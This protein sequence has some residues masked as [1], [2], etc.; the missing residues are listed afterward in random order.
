M[1]VLFL[2]TPPT[3]ES[4][5]LISGRPSAADLACRGIAE[6]LYRRIKKD[7]T[8]IG[9]QITKVFPKIPKLMIWPHRLVYCS[10][11]VVWMMP[12]LNISFVREICQ[13]L[14]AFFAIILWAIKNIGRKRIVCCYNLE[15]PPF[16]FS[17][18]ACK[19][20]HT[21]YVPVLHDMGLVLFGG[22]GFFRRTYHAILE[23]AI[24]RFLPRVDGAAIICD[25][26]KTRYLSNNKTML[27]DGGITDEVKNRLFPLERISTNE[28]T[29]F[30]MAGGLSDYNGVTWIL[31]A[32]KLN[33]NPNIEV[34][35]AGDGVKKEEIRKSSETDC[36]IKYL[37]SLS[38]DDLFL[39]YQES[40]CILNT[41]VTGEID[42]SLYFPS[43]FLEALAVGRMVLSSCTGHLERDYGSYC[44]LIKVETP[45]ALSDMFDQIASMQPEERDRMGARAREF[46][47]K[48][49]TW[50]EQTARLQ[51]FFSELTEL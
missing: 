10:G 32:M 46:M 23:K 36:R 25:A 22:G 42:T 31:D 37:G 35:F 7:F 50:D 15:Q 19:L 47:L 49:H 14:N 1:K 18:M 27:L 30:I 21:K 3:N 13:G 28:R 12:A 9:F 33:K 20:T 40:D 44:M 11:M 16:I 6:G 2:N 8:A 45:S 34:R 38:H 51:Q 4:G 29:I 17:L 26:I 5:L 39:Q 24:V 43:K 41:R 48:T